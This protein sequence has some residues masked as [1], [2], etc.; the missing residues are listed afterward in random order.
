[1]AL[2]PDY[3]TVAQLKAYLRIPLPVVPGSPTASE[4]EDDVALA[5]AITAAS[6]AIDQAAGRQFGKLSTAA[7]RYYRPEWWRSFAGHRL[8]MVT[9]DDLMSS[10]GLV[11]KTDSTGLGDY[12]IAQ[13]DYRLWPYNAASDGK[14]W[15]ALIFPTANYVYPS[16]VGHLLPS[17]EGSVE[18]TALWGWTAFPDT[19]VNGT[20][21]QASRYFK[22]KDAPFGIAGS[23][24]SGSEMRLL[25]K[26]DPD[27]RMMVGSGYKR[28]WGAA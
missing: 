25:A 16:A 28:R 6:R 19:I 26:L 5:W 27:V 13:T 3:A 17:A 8:L 24:D 10:T 4:S 22:R 11:V 12:N 18:V 7:A 1:M 23:P 14:P 2:H 15:T 20:L 21:L 9:I